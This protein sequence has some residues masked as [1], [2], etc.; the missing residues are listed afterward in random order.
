MRGGMG[1]L[2]QGG[3]LTLCRHRSADY[4]V[5]IL[6]MGAWL[7]NGQCQEEAKQSTTGMLSD[8][9]SDSYDSYWC[10]GGARSPPSAGSGGTG[11]GEVGG[12]SPLVFGVL[13]LPS[14]SARAQLYTDSTSEDWSHF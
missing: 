2:T 3:P 11:G 13:V 12:T 1:S 5:Y 8:K 4:L 14:T 9:G 6:S 10:Y 7:P